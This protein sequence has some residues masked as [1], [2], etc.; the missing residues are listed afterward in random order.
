MSFRFEPIYGSVL[1]TVVLAAMVVAVIALVSPP[2]SNPS[3]R[4]WLI[5]LRSAAALALMLVISR[6]TVVQTD[7]QPTEAALVVAM[8]VSESMNV[9]DG[10]DETRW[11]QQVDAARR[12]TSK[13]GDLAERLTVEWMA[14]DRLARPMGTGDAAMQKA[15]SSPPTG[16]STS[17]AAPLSSSLQ[18]AN[19]QPIVGVVLLGDGAVTSRGGSGLK[20][21]NQTS[22]DQATGPDSILQSAEQS[23][24][25]L[26]SIGVPLWTVPIGPAPRETMT[27]DVAIEALPESYRV[28]GGNYFDVQFE[29]ASKGVAGTEI[30]V[31]LRWIASDGTVTDAASR[32]VLSEQSLD[33]QSVR[34]TLDAPE[35][36]SYRL[37]VTAPPRDGEQRT[38]NNTQLSFVDVQAGGGRVFVL[39]GQPRAEQYFLRLTLSGF[40]DLDLAYQLVNEDSRQRWPTRLGDVFRSRQFDVFVLGD[41]EAAALGDEQLKQLAEAVANGAGLITLGGFR[42]YGAGGYDASPLADALPI[43]MQRVGRSGTDGASGQIQGPIRLQSVVQHP[44]TDIQNDLGPVDW[45]NLPPM[46]GASDIGQPR[47]N[48]PGV[49]VLL[50]TSQ[51]QPML[52]IGEYGR[53]RV[54]SVAFDESHRWFRGGRKDIHERFWRQLVLWLLAREDSDSADIQI[55]LDSRR[56]ASEASTEFRA[57]LSI[58]DVAS[59]VQWTATAVDQN[60][61]STDITIESQSTNQVASSF[62]EESEV[63]ALGTL[64]DLPP[65]VYTLRLLAESVGLSSPARG[66]IAFQVLDENLELANPMADPVYL[67][68]LADLTA[69]QNGRAFEPTEID[70]LAELIQKLRRENVAPVVEK[71]RLGDGPISG[72]SVFLLFAS[73]LCAEWIL[74]R[75]WGL[76]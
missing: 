9:T 49:E 55:E 53:G 56:F 63:T 72:W 18:L 48:A 13:L 10:T 17:L 29:V 64:S 23:A 73:A 7:D 25:V 12:L 36:G 19:Q 69:D 3:Q 35:A 22:S 60:G 20:P 59:S 76:V 50:A 32:R 54:A 30:P 37:E 15:I 57:N 4:R 43:Q 68:Q 45:V 24:Q 62:A 66:E 75:R 11:Q 16:R 33:R 67:R 58:K 38:E 2:T 6:P 5:A 51:N 21:A 52:V 65:G 71:K 28:F 44:I 41:L 47:L 39:E 46:Q 74:R 34:V 70:A 27:R 8:D 61:T 26:N 14:Y 40:R 31:R 1:L 42:S